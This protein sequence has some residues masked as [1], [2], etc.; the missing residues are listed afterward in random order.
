MTTKPN[1]FPGFSFDGH[2]IN[3]QDEFR[4]RLA[5]LT[6]IGK[7]AKVGSM[8]AAAPSLYE[9]AALLEAA[10]LAHANCDECDGEGVPELCGECFPLFDEARVK[11]RS[12]LRAA[13]GEEV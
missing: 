6:E 1:A 9:A 5:T 8:L 7:A 11:R 4:S 3:G 13:R 10:E 2:G 12:A